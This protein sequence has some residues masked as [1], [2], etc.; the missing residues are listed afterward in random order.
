[1]STTSTKHKNIGSS[2]DDFL[3]EEGLLNEAEEVAIK[4]VLAFQIE[5]MMKEKSLSKTAM[6]SKMQT[7]RSSLNRLLDPFNGSI[8]LQTMMKAATALGRRLNVRL[9]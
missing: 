3:E 4:R 2:L 9:I 1:M 5:Q 7:S 6:A 8:T